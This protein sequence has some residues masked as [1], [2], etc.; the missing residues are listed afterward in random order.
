[1]NILITGSDGFIGKHLCFFLKKKKIKFFP[2]KSKSNN[3]FFFKKKKNQNYTHIIHLEHSYLDKKKNIRLAKKLLS[4]AKKNNIKKFIFTSTCVYKYKNKKKIGN[5][6]SG[7]NEYVKTKIILEKLFI[8]Y[9]KIKKIEDLIIL[10]IFNV[11]GKFQSKKYYVIPSL[12]SRFKSK[13]KSI[14]LRYP[15]NKRDFIYV[16]DVISAIYKSLNLSNLHFFDIGS[17]KSLSIYSLAK[18]IRLLLGSDK[19]IHFI[20]PYISDLNSYSKASL[21]NYEKNKLINWM[22]KVQIDRGLKMIK[23]Y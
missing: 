18:K 23:N 4:F 2:L 17:G 19:K 14:N 12:I 10:R 5:Y 13:D 9:Y 11:Y 22:P 20:K 6:L 7:I 15:F 21:K 1:M 8:K 3:N 16:D